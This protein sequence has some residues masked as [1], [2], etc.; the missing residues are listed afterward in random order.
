MIDGRQISHRANAYETKGDI[1]DPLQIGPV[2]S[3]WPTGHFVLKQLDML[4]DVLHT[5]LPDIAQIL[6]RLGDA[7][8]QRARVRR[9]II[10]D[11][12]LPDVQ[13][14]WLI[15]FELSSGSGVVQAP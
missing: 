15:W 11:V 14:V 1:I 6:I 2:E 8:L 10:R 9:Q 4:V 3:R 7:L 5:R 13:E 12:W